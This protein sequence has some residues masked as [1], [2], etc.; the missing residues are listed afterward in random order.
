[1]LPDNSSTR[2]HL[3]IFESIRRDAS[4]PQA[5]IA[6]KV[7]CKMTP[8]HKYIYIS[9]NQLFISCHILFICVFWVLGFFLKFYLSLNSRVSGTAS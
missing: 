4:L 2:L 6:T 9:I 3:Y 8:H 1:M 5:L 7:H